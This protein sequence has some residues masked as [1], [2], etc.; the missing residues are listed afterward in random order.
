MRSNNS[1][2]AAFLIENVFNTLTSNQIEEIL[3]C[4]KDLEY[5]CFN[6]GVDSQVSAGINFS[7]TVKDVAGQINRR[8]LLLFLRLIEAGKK[9]D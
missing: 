9:D 8:D 1:N 5:A 3:R 2:K 7:E 6:L 4:V